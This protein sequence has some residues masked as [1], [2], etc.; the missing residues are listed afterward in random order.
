M[1]LSQKTVRADWGPGEHSTAQRGRL[2]TLWLVRRQWRACSP[3]GPGE[4]EPSRA[5]GLVGE[6]R[7]NKP[8]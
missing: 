3:P 2:F 4:K 5:R 8:G 1:S 7:K 6:T